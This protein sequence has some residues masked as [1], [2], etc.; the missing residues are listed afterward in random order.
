MPLTGLVSHSGGILTTGQSPKKKPEG[1]NQGRQLQRLLDVW[2]RNGSASGPTACHLHDGDDDDDD[3]DDDDDDDDDEDEINFHFEGK[4]KLQIFK[5]K[6][7]YEN[8]WS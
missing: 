1:R 2:D 8:I 7:A 6:S 3:G 4:Y 5:K